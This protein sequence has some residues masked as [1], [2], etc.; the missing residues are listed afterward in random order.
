M[1]RT[2]RLICA[3]AVLAVFSVPALGQLVDAKGDAEDIF[4]A[5]PPLLDIDTFSVSFDETTLFVEMTFHTPV[6]APS[7]SLA[8]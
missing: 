5:G 3:V 7:S 4:G 8:E 1:L 2:K 6:S